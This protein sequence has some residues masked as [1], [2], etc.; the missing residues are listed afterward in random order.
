VNPN[1]PVI[2]TANMWD[3]PQYLE[4]MTPYADKNVAYAVHYYQ[5]MDFTHQGAS[6]V[7]QYANEQNVPF[8][9]AGAAQIQSDFTA[10][11]NWATSNHAFVDIDEFGV[12]TTAPQADKAA[13]LTDLRT[14]ANQDNF[15]WDVWDY[16]KAFSITTTESNGNH[17]IPDQFLQALGW[18]PYLSPEP[19]W[20]SYLS[21]EQSA[22][23]HILIA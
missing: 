9:S 21:P 10:L 23:D 16:D 11:H 18:G 4:Q 7:P 20:T 3:S 2:A 19:D 13:W 6:W 1:I 5:P 14:V 8:T 15:G 17:V 22:S 12:I